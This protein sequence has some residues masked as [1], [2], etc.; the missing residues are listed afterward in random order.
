MRFY[1]SRLVWNV[2]VVSSSLESVLEKGLNP[3]P[4]ILMFQGNAMAVLERIP[5]LKKVPASSVWDRNTSAMSSG[6]HSLV[7]QSRLPFI[8]FWGNIC[9]ET[10]KTLSHTTTD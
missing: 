3:I 9:I 5:L 1:Q 8:G 7:V 6:R 10:R 2:I 4:S